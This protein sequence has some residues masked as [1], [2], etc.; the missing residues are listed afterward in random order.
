MNFTRPFL[1]RVQ[2]VVSGDET[3]ML[4]STEVQTLGVMAAVY[5]LR[6]ILC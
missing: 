5:A 1:H 6:M 2:W 4:Y 3:I